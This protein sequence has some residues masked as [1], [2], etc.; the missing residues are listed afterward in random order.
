MSRYWVNG[1]PREL[2]LLGHVAEKIYAVEQ[3]SGNCYAIAAAMLANGLACGTLRYGHYWGPVDEGS[4]FYDTAVTLGWTPHGWIETDKH[5]IDPTRWVFTLEDPE[6][7]LG[8]RSTYDEEYDVGGNQ[9]RMMTLK[10]PP[11]FERAK[12]SV[13]PVVVPKRLRLAV[14]AVG[15]RLN[16]GRL[17]YNQIFWL[18]NLP[19]K[20]FVAKVKEIF[21]WLE[22]LDMGALIP[23]DNRDFV[24]ERKRCVSRR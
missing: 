1:K 24:L 15:L 12:Y 20:L 18:A 6:I 9:R 16:R 13:K 19:P 23:I 2:P 22:D 11:P 14:E 7:F 17:S 5:I 4:S 8:L 10:S 21:L 3:W